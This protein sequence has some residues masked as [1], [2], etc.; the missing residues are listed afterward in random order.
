MLGL[1][2]ILV[3]ATPAVRWYAGRLAGPWA[4]ARGD[5]LILLGSDGPTEDVMGQSTYWRCFYGVLAWRD[6]G[7][8]SVV[9]SGGHGV[10][11]SMRDFLVAAGVPADKIL[12]ENRSETTRENAILTAAALRGMEGRKI[13]VTA[14]FHAYR[15]V[16]AFRRAGVEVTASP[17]PFAV[18]RFNT[19]TER[20]PIFLEM[21]LETAK[22]VDYRVR[23]WI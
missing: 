4:A 5:I 23:G 2:M 19:W 7:F 16:R 10:A 6:G 1:L 13:L 21:L 17:F 9:V 3:T 11:E 20:W 18:K 22:I 15:S 14:D 12:L 8:K